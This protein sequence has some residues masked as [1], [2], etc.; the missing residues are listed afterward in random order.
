MEYLRTIQQPLDTFA[1]TVEEYHAAHLALDR[2]R[3][4]TG[5][6]LGLLDAVADRG[7]AEM[8]R[9][10]E[11][12][13]KTT[14][15]RQDH[16]TECGRLK[17]YL[18]ALEHHTARKELEERRECLTAAKQQIDV[19]ERNA[20]LIE[21]HGKWRD[22]KEA[23]DRL[24]P[25]EEQCQKLEA[26]EQDLLADV[27]NAGTTCLA[28]LQESN[29]DL[30]G[31]RSRV[32][33]DLASVQKRLDTL[34]E[35]QREL[36]K[37]QAWLE[38]TLESLRAKDSAANAARAE[39]VLLG[40]L[41]R[42]EDPRQAYE[43]HVTARTRA[44][45]QVATQA[46]VVVDLND[47]LLRFQTKAQPLD[48]E[49]ARAVQS[50][51]AAEAEQANN[52]A[53]KGRLQA[54]PSLCW[55]LD[56]NDLALADEGILEAVA[57][58]IQNRSS[59]R[60]DLSQKLADLKRRLSP[61]VD[62]ENGLLAPPGDT[63]TARLALLARGMSVFT[64]GSWL[65]NFDLDKAKRAIAADPGRYTGLMVFT[66]PELDEIRAMAGFVTGLDHPVMVSIAS[67]EDSPAESPDR[68]VLL[69]EH[70]ATFNR[71]EA[72]ELA[73]R[74]RREL[75]EQESVFDFMSRRLEDARG[76]FSVLRQFLGR[77]PRG[78]LGTLDD[79]VAHANAAL[80]DCER[81]ILA[82]QEA[83]TVATQELAD[84]KIELERRNDEAGACR[85]R[86]QQMHDW[87]LKFEDILD[88]QRLPQTEKELAAAKETIQ[89]SQEAA[90]PL[91]R[92]AEGCRNRAAELTSQ[93]NSNEEAKNE[94]PE[95]HRKGM[96]L[97]WS[98][99]RA[100]IAYSDAKR[101]LEQSHT[102]QSQALFARREERRDAV[103]RARQELN[104]FC[105]VKNVDPGDAAE[106]SLST[107]YEDTCAQAGRSLEE[108]KKRHS[109]AEHEVE[110][111][112]EAVNQ[113]SMPANYRKHHD[114]DEPRDGEHGRELISRTQERISAEGEAIREAQEAL[115][116]LARD[117][118][119][120][121]G[122]Q[123]EVSGLK[124]DWQNDPG[125]ASI[126]W[127]AEELPGADEAIG[128]A[129]KVLETYRRANRRFH[130]AQETR[131]AAYRAVDGESRNR[132]WDDVDTD[133]R[134][135]VQRGA[136]SLTEIV[137][138]VRHEYE[139][140]RNVI[141]DSLKR[142]EEAVTQITDRLTTLV[143]TDG[144]ALISHAQTGSR[145][146]DDIGEWSQRP[147][148]KIELS[149]TGAG[150]FRRLTS[151]PIATR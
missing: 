135:A 55:A 88:N 47:K 147:F 120:L 106:L 16:E 82:N 141:T 10:E 93:I 146:P 53:E 21:A 139:T 58:A 72:G 51:R 3:V 101:R 13:R 63:E 48:E 104:R 33:N 28:R 59:Q 22:V 38:A 19:A 45:G 133:K 77:F 86:E 107:S 118:V 75:G 132:R 119:I 18:Q 40:V 9:G 85:H 149:G 14:T 136:D 60:D 80:S 83:I 79:A 105:R 98:L 125:L 46:P 64:A 148:L 57:A 111:A 49:R 54:L 91:N 41:E 102:D 29:D 35:D 20:A 32:R 2:S 39:L 100:R 11:E 65:N 114:D 95:D 108:A 76:D 112:R 99:T 31:Q 121:Q 69:P 36:L 142:A 145:L 96:D 126:P 137:E 25:I 138:A 94:I 116:N 37:R 74:L 109:I 81:R 26:A 44:D 12:Q 4:E 134:R 143:K 6:I 131:D 110:L 151:L 103:T 130:T 122:Q 124:G 27:R 78:D 8:R 50:L 67:M 113:H 73:T 117:Q 150:I 34:N 89:R 71:R 115:H 144:L 62:V 97:N 24:A 127:T 42:E 30:V 70:P 123:R 23:E 61:L 43:R 56:A 68:L 128:T 5:R 15:Q 87:L 140:W 52:Q 17:V 129:R 92:D 7:A 66:Q 84:G 1:A 90:E